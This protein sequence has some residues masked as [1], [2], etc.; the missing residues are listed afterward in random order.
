MIIVW[1]V[2]CWLFWIKKYI[3][4]IANKIIR[5]T[6]F[7]N[8]ALIVKPF[9]TF[10]LQTVLQIKTAIKWTKTPWKH[11]SLPN[12][13]TRAC[14]NLLLYIRIHTAHVK[15][16]SDI[17]QNHKP[18]HT[19]NKN[20]TNLIDTI[21]RNKAH[22]F[23]L[24]FTNEHGEIASKNKIIIERINKVKPSNICQQKNNK[25]YDEYKMN[26]SNR[27]RISLR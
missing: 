13:T 22:T 27:S 20:R 14:N 1:S 8:L 17:K 12:F 7:N 4:S 6:K 21:R 15:K 25:S 26:L 5:F 16:L 2:K 24:N 11:L 23:A 18:Q 19:I 9:F 10:I 3:L